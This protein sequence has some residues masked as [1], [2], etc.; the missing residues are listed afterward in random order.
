VLEFACWGRPLEAGDVAHK[1]H[2]AAE[3]DSVKL[4]PSPLI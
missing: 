4:A 2:T 3:L 1:G